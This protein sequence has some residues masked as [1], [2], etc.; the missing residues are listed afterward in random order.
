MLTHRNLVANVLQTVAAE[1]PLDPSSVLIGVLPMY[2]IYGMQCIMNCGGLYQG[3]T[4]VTLPKYHL[5]DFLEVCQST[6][7]PSFVS[8]R[9]PFPDRLMQDTGLREPIWFRPS[10]SS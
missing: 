1:G 5:K 8:L 4:L 7:T 2:H 3:T 10:S 6:L 9:Q